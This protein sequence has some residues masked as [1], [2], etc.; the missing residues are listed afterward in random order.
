MCLKTAHMYRRLIQLSPSKDNPNEPEHQEK[1]TK[2]DPEY[3]EWVS[4]K[5]EWVLWK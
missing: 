4:W 3:S 2:E 5:D 1:N